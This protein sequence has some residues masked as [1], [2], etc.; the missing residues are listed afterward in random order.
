MPEIYIW[1]ALLC[2][3]Y[4]GEAIWERLWPEHGAQRSASRSRVRG[5]DCRSTRCLGDIRNRA[6]AT[7]YGRNDSEAG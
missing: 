2:L 4:L 1:I 7:S 3:G 6:L 5:G